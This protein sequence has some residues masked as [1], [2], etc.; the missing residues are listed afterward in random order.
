MAQYAT[1]KHAWAI[2]DICGFRFPYRHLRQQIREARKTSLWVCAE[3]QDKDVPRR[4]GPISDPQ[5][6]RHPRPDHS[7]EPSRRILHWRPTDTFELN[8]RLGEFEVT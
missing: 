2:C 4:L 5:A 8:A 1:G 6:L 7:L 3:C